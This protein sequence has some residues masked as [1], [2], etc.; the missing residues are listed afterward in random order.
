MVRDV[1]VTPNAH[2]LA[3]R[4]AASDHFSTDSDVSADGHRWAVG[5]APT[6][7]MNIAWTSS[8]GGRRTG[9]VTS[10]APGRRAIFGGADAPMPEDEPE[11]G[12]LWEHVAN[13][14]LKILNY[15]EG[16]E[17]E[18][19]DEAVGTAPEGQRLLL[20]SPVPDP[21]FA[22][23]DRLY[24]TFNLGIPDQYRFAEF[25]RDFPRRLARGYKPA[26]TVI[27]LPDDHAANS[28]PE[29]G[30][31]YRASYVADNDLALGKIVSLISHNAIWKESAI[32]VIEDDAQSGVDHVDAHRS[33]LL[34]ISPWVREGYI[35]HIATSTVSAQKTIYQ[36][37]GLGTLNLEDALSA[38]LSDVFTTQPDFT[39]YDTLPSALRVFD[40]AKARIARPR[41][42]EQAREL[43]DCDDVGEIQHQFNRSSSHKRST[44]HSAPALQ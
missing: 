2:A 23:T 24:P 40:P 14:K 6:P 13:A 8:Y 38:R 22:S 4:F 36:L 29:D 42:A 11:F 19:S 1:G 37:L 9:D 5:I 34:V 33:V 17:L 12:S 18:G 27:R 10:K 25:Q 28:R 31:P 16:L 32:F 7:W 41:S 39:P 35:S 26:L 21:V 3:M 20:N 44:T 15:G 43:L 30:Y